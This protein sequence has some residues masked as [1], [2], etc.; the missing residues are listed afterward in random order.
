MNSIQLL[1]FLLIHIF[2][3]NSKRMVIPIPHVAFAFSLY[4]YI[5]THTKRER[6]RFLISTN[7]MMMH[8]ILLD[9]GGS[10]S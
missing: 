5:Y 3:P 6:D 1:L 9:F 2:I 4:R 10:V 7:I 8:K